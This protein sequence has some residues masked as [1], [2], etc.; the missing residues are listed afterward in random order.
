P[1]YTW[2]M[3]SPFFLAAPAAVLFSH[4]LYPHP[5]VYYLISHTVMNIG[6]A[7]CLDWCVTYHTG[8]VGW[9]LNSRPLVSIGVASYS[10]Y[11]WQQMF[12]N[13]DSL[14]TVARF[15]LNIALVAAAAAAS[16]FV[17]E[18][19]CLNLR[20][21][22]ERRYFAPREKARE[23]AQPQISPIPENPLA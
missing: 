10:L 7:L 23:F 6:I 17:V 12:L 14:S 16:Y 9:I 20:Q 13:R 18:K 21:A 11:L 15:P 8:R 22:L 19:P 3:E 5:T 1:L 4:M 2:F